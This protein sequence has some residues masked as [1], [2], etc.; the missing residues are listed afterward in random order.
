[1]VLIIDGPSISQMAKKTGEISRTA[2]EVTSDAG[3]AEAYADEF[4]DTFNTNA[5]TLRRYANNRFNAADTV[6]ELRF[7]DRE[8]DRSKRYLVATADES[9]G[10]LEEARVV[11][12]GRFADLDRSVDRHIA[13]DWHLSRNAAVELETFVE[14]FADRNE[15]PSQAYLAKTAAKYGDSVEGDLVNE[16]IGR[17]DG[18]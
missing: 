2:A 1:M 4:Q 9:T 16:L 8:G 11:D 7:A 12:P 5:G 14:K 6:A 18:S 13:A 15:D 17:F 3:N 10:N